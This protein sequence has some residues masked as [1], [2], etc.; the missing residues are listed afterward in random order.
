[1]RVGKMHSLMIV[2]ERTI[3]PW[4]GFWTPFFANDFD[5]VF[6]LLFYESLEPFIILDKGT[7][8]ENGLC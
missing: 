2:K 5:S 1:L 6:S 4:Q 7:A 3:G 8:K